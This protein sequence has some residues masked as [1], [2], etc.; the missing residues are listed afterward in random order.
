LSYG[1]AP[2]RRFGSFAFRVP[3]LA[4]Q[5]ETQ[6]SQPKTAAAQAAQKGL[7][8]EAREESASEGVRKA[9]RW[10]ETIER[11]EPYESFSAA[12]KAY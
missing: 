8:G 12:W 2:G 5:S 3:S 4:L 7:R 1:R 11:N 9:V 6:N 10:S